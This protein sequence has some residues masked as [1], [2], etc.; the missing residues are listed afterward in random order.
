MDVSRWPL[1]A[2]ATETWYAK[3]T[4]GKLMVSPADAEP[5]AP[6]DAWPDD[7]VLAEGL[8]RYEQSV[9]TPVTLQLVSL[10]PGP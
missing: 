3:P 1:F 2:G 8:H 4:G 7:M 9:M 10:T 5:M 6:M